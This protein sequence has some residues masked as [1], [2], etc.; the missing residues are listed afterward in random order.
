MRQPSTVSNSCWLRSND[1]SALVKTYGAR[2]IDSTPP[3]I[4]TSF[5]PKAIDC[6]AE[7]MACKLEPH[8]RLIVA[9][10][11]ETGEPASNAAMRATSR[12]SSP[13]A[14]AAPKKIS[15]MRS[16]SIPVR[17]TTAETAVAAR[18][19][20]RTLDNAPRYRPIG[21][22]TASTIQTSRRVVTLRSNQE[23]SIR[24]RRLAFQAVR[25]EDRA[26]T[27]S[28]RARTPNL[29]RQPPVRECARYGV[30]R[31]RDPIRQALADSWRPVSSR[32]R[33]PPDRRRPV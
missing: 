3:A 6:A 5:S 26:T 32:D 1:A 7:L 16:G 27:A 13:L 17:R 25:L 14:F 29:R 21:V 31:S 2:V 22:R 12:L 23:A 9:P 4:A 18:S 30:R 15:S 33:Y 28:G 8:K 20:G 10:A 24:L 11:T 19:S